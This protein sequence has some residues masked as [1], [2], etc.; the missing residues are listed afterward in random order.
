MRIWKRLLMAV[1][2]CAI[3]SFTA[4]AAE[5][6]PVK[7]ERVK[8]KFESFRPKDGYVK[9]T[10][11]GTGYSVVDCEII[12]DS[13]I[14]NW[15]SSYCARLQIE[16]TAD[17]GYEFRKKGKSYFDL[18]GSDFYRY[19]SSDYDDKEVIWLCVDMAPLNR[20]IGVPLDPVWT[21][22]G[23]AKWTVAYKA[24]SGTSLTKV[25]I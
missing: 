24:E 17:D 21:A 23:T 18:K 20:S 15:N 9:I 6:D 1:C 3:W 13:D 4:L 8:L 25:D 5:S 16:L 7:I 2:L 12:N 19:E 10:N 11:L 22:D 14:D